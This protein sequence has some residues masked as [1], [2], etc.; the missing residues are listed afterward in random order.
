MQIK[1]AVIT[2]AARGGRLYPVGDTVQ[3]AMLPIAD[4]DNVHKP[5]LQIIAE[6]AFV[7][8]IEEICIVCAPGDE[9]RYQA[10]FKALR[11]NLS[12][13]YS[14]VDWAQQQAQKIDFLLERL[15]FVVQ[16][17][18][19]GY[20]HAV[21]C[22]KSFANG[23]AFLLLLGDHLYLSNTDQRCAKQLI[24]VSSDSECSVSA[25]NATP[26]YLIGQYGTLTGRP[27]SGQA[28]CYEIE[29]IIEKPSLSEAEL[30]LMTPG[31][32][33][34]HY[35]C[36]FGMHVLEASIFELLEEHIHQLPQDADVQLTPALQ[37]LSEQHNYLAMQMRGRRYNLGTHYGWLDAQIAFGLQ[38]NNSEALLSSITQ[39]LAMARLSNK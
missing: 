22:A 9:P 20:G 39:E 2:A 29:K 38:G 25:V 31:L 10:A 5:V 21:H 7:S 37:G 34:A 11:Y 33:A 14:G 3:K 18:T 13:A 23:E 36:F 6:E 26:E 24:D 16:E 30:H 27:V 8:G 17:K 12:Q 1:K 32:K 35:L 15:S 28:G 4:L 19:L